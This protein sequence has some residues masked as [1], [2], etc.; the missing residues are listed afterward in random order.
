[1]LLA[2]GVPVS[3]Q[4]IAVPLN[5]PGDVIENTLHQWWGVYYDAQL[6]VTG[7]WGLALPQTAHRLTIEGKTLY[8]W[9]AWD[10]L[11]IPELIGKTISI[12]SRCPATEQNIRL[13]VGPHGIIDR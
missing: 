9:C 2:E 8:A 4:Q 7:Y 5:L 12:E 11:F 10:T 1:R 3:R 6:H 13:T